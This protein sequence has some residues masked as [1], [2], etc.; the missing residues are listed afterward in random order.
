MVRFTRPRRSSAMRSISP[1]RTGCIS[2][3]QS[4]DLRV[5]LAKPAVMPPDTPLHRQTRIQRLRDGSP[6][7][8]EDA[9]ILFLPSRSLELVI[10]AFGAPARQLGDVVDTEGV[11]V[12]FDGWTHRPEISKSAR[13]FRALPA[14]L[15]MATAS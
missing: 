5:V 1:L 6:E 13:V 3:R 15:L 14:A 4:R 7:R 8:V 11:Q 9:R 2:S 10:Q 12:P